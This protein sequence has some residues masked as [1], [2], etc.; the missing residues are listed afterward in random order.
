M[1]NFYFVD[2][3][4][5]FYFAI[6]KNIHRFA[7]ASVNNKY[8]FYTFTYFQLNLR[9]TASWKRKFILMTKP[10]KN[11]YDIFKATNWLQEFG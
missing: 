1:E 6:T 11:L 9:D 5:S 3:N 10:T 7:N 2:K 8:D 4:I